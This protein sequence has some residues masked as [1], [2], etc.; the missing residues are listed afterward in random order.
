MAQHDIDDYVN[1]ARLLMQLYLDRFG[2]D[3]DM[4]RLNQQRYTHRLCRGIYRKIAHRAPPEL[5][6]VYLDGVAL[7]M[8]E[9]NINDRTAGE[10]IG[11]GFAGQD[12]PVFAT[13]RLVKTDYYRRFL[14]LLCRGRFAQ[15]PLV[16]NT[17]AVSLSLLKA[18]A[19]GDLLGFLRL[20]W[21]A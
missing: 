6:P 10:F 1:Q 13:Q 15:L 11:L 16:E 14:F 12:R 4:F 7:V 19:I 5:M 9:F 20:S 2:A 21:T 18:G 3:S 8:E 17:S